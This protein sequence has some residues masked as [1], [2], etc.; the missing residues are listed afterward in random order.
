MKL[1]ATCFFLF[2]VLICSSS[3]TKAQTKNT[4]SKITGSLTEK[5]G[6]PFQAILTVLKENDSTFKKTIAVTENQSY[7]FEDLGVGKYTIEV[8]SLG[9]QNIV[10]V[11]EVDSLT[12]IIKHDFILVEDTQNLAAVSIVGKKRLIERYSDKTVINVENS[13]IATG[14]SALEILARAPGVSVSQDGTISIKGKS[15][16]NVLIDGKSTYLSAEQL[17]ARLRSLNSNTIK[18]IEV[19]TSPTAKYDAA[20]NAGIIDIKLKKNSNYGTNGNLELGAGYSRNA[21]SNAGISLNHRTKDLNIFGNF[22]NSSSKLFEDL[23]IQ[24]VNDDN[25]EKTYFH[26]QNFQTNSSHDNNYK[27]GLDYFLDSKNTIGILASGYFNNGHD[28]SIGNTFIGKSF[29]QVDS[30]VKANNP[31]TNKA[32]HQAYNLN[33][34]LAIDTL[35]KEFSVDLDYA[36]YQ[37]DV[38][39]TYNNDFFLADGTS[40]KARSIFRNATPSTV[41]IWAAKADYTHPFSDK[42]KLALGLKSSKVSTA[43]DFRFENLISNNWQNDISRSNKFNYTENINAAYA[44]ISHDFGTT[45]IEAGLRAEQTRSNANAINDQKTVKRSY[46]DLFPSISITQS[47]SEAHKLSLAYNRRIDRPDYKSLNPFVYFVD[48]YTFSQGN[49]FLNAQYTNSLSLT[50]NYDEKLNIAAGYSLTKGLI[51]DVF[52]ADEAAKTLY[53]TTQNL[54]RQYAYDLT[55]SAPTTLTKFWSMDNSLTIAYNQTQTDN[56]NGFAY[57]KKKVNFTLNSSHSF[58]ISPTTTAELSG[59]YTS[60]QIYG[61]YAIKP[62]YGIDLGLKKS[63]LDNK[64]SLKFAVNDV[65]NTRKARVNSAVSNLAY[66]LSQKQESNMFRLSFSYAFGNSNVKSA[67]DRQSGVATEEGRIK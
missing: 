28:K 36:K 27:V 29:N 30:L 51:T 16:V 7:S 50:Y 12:Q 54:G 31:S 56:L 44:T 20:G 34:K 61:T 38:Q 17:A 39:T 5:N 65:L 25:G 33:Y 21:Q 24:R 45:S 42:T 8:K 37:S 62:Y 3:S 43:N 23:D 59:N 58:T 15:G 32:N 18:S 49:P 47:L 19:I 64:F 48:L 11:F 6:T 26:Q 60:A 41:K 52:L 22:S 53:V 1:T 14:N 13:S 57:N 55:L 66:S 40:Q 35:G 9:F 4:G 63:F 2:C 10:F 46:F 67:R